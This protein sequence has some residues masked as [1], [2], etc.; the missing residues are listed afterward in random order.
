M[1]LPK[2]NER[3]CDALAVRVNEHIANNGVAAYPCI[4]MR[5]GTGRYQEFVV[6]GIRKR[7]WDEGNEYCAL[8]AKPAAIEKL[9][10]RADIELTLSQD[11]LE[12]LVRGCGYEV[13]EVLAEYSATPK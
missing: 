2:Y 13:E 8:L 3:T 6:I 10:P 11:W 1:T 7:G 5:I 12:R 9:K 4:E